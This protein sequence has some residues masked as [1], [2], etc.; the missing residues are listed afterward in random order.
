MPNLPGAGGDSRSLPGRSRAKLQ[1][2]LTSYLPTM[3]IRFPKPLGFLKK[4]TDSESRK[5]KETDEKKG[6]ARAS[7]GGAASGKGGATAS[8]SK[9]GLAP[10]NDALASSGRDVLAPP[11][12]S[13][14]VESRTVQ[15][16]LQG[17]GAFDTAELVRRLASAGHNPWQEESSSLVVWP[18]S[19]LAAPFEEGVL[20]VASL[21]IRPGE[22][23]G[24]RLAEALARLRPDAVCLEPLDEAAARQLGERLAMHAAYTRRGGKMVL[25]RHP[26]TLAEE[27]PCDGLP[28]GAPPGGAGATGRSI[29]R[30]ALRVG[31]RRIDILVALVP[32]G[33]PDS[34]GGELRKLT[35]YVEVLKGAGRSA[36]VAVHFE[37]AP[38]AGPML[39]RLQ[40]LLQRGE[41]EPSPAGG[42]RLDAILATRDVRLAPGRPCEVRWG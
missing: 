11:A 37:G 23:E 8:S 34:S 28:A 29:I 12:E 40:G 30:V 25:S 35:E 21:H 17:T 41:P 15:A 27:I 4:L 19:D 10:S 20:R 3:S 13:Q 1:G 5:E 36:L 14:A 31:T 42:V 33:V 22:L 7:K 2:P 9:G 32:A 18:R 16:R 24:E 6:G 26:I 38:P 39:D